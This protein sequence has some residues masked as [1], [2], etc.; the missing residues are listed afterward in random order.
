MI[1]KVCL[2]LLSCV[3][4]GQVV[5]KL[6]ECDKYIDSEPILGKQAEFLVAPMYYS[7]NTSP[8]VK[9]VEVEVPKYDP[10]AVNIDLNLKNSN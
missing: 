6:R 4:A 3:N 7:G 9:F 2:L 5:E 10:V 8:F 1:I